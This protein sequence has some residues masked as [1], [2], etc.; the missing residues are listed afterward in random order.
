MGEAWSDWYALRLPGRATAWSTTPRTPGEIDIGDYS[1]LDAARAAHARRST[2]PSTRPTPACPGGAATGAGGYTL[3]DFGKV[4]GAPGGP[5]RRR[6]LGRDAVGPAPG[7]R[8]RPAARRRL[9]RRRASSPTACGSRRPSR[10]CSTCATR[11]WPPTQIDFGGAHHDLALDG[12]RASAAWATSPRA[13]DGGDTQPARGLQLAAGSERAEGHGH[14]RRHRR[15]HRRCRSRGVRV[16]FG[17]RRPRPEFATTSPPRPTRT[18]A[19]RSTGVPAGPTRSSTFPRRAASTPRSPPTSRSPQDAT[20]TTQRRAA[21]D[22]SRAERR[23]GDHGTVTTTRAPAFGCGVDQ[24]FDQSAGHGLVGVQPDQRGSG[25][26]RG[27]PA[28]GGDRA[29]GDDRRQRR[30]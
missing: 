3:G 28:D 11:S 4:A 21:R 6:D 24:A 18:G 22:W 16:G 23:R 13:T 14:R 2:A 30:S 19:T 1:D 15:R 26:P 8:S 27:R 7:A 5:R 12:V 20:T 17:G 9:G 10:R 29:A 25:Q